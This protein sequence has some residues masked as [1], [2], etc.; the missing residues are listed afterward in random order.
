MAITGFSFKKTQ[1]GKVIGVP[2][3]KQRPHRVELISNMIDQGEDPSDVFF[4]FHMEDCENASG[5]DLIK[6]ENKLFKKW[7][8]IQSAM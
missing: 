1:D 2:G 4:N 6:K 7:E 8:K 3:K 5:A